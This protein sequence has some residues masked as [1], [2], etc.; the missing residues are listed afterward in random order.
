MARK[1]FPPG[2]WCFTWT[3]ITA[4]SSDSVCFSLLWKNCHYLK[5]TTIYYF[6]MD[7]TNYLIG[8][9]IRC[10][11]WVSQVSV[12]LVLFEGTKGWIAFC[13]HVLLYFF[14][15]FL[16]FPSLSLFYFAF[17]FPHPVSGGYWRLLFHVYIILISASADTF[18]SLFSFLWPL[19]L[20]PFLSP[21]LLF[22]NTWAWAYI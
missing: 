11:K 20:L 16:V 15:D 14:F 12:R 18:S 17:C 7:D 21:S 6:K 4:T 3:A 5:I 13:S 22:E 8:F 1:I 9:Q 10:L 2:L 19:S